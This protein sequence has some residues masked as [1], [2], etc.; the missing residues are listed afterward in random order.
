LSLQGWERVETFFLEGDSAGQMPKQ[1]SDISVAHPGGPS[2]FTIMSL[3]R[4][5]IFFYEDEFSH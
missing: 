2:S 4:I 3:Q 5:E 1:R